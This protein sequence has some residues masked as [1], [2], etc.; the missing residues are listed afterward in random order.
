MKSDISD[1]RIE[2][3]QAMPVFGGIS[4]HVLRF[5]LP[6]TKHRNLTAGEILFQEGDSANSL[7]VLESGEIELL[8]QWE[9][10]QYKLKS[11]RRGDCCGEVSLIDLQLR[12]TTALATT[13]CSLIEI[14]AANLHQLYKKDREQFTLIYLNMAR[15]VCRRLRE[16]DHRAFAADMEALKVA[17]CR[18][19]P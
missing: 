14:S 9:G 15:E 10:H 18:Q 19:T 8:K 1:N 17:K 16:A 12:S 13:D 11:L 2:L 7:F 6:F 3:L 5:L 4:A